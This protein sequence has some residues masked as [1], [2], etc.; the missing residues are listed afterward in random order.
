M[1]VE[2]YVDAKLANFEIVL[3]KTL[4]AVERGR[5]KLS[6]RHELERL[7][8]GGPAEGEPATFLDEP[9]GD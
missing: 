6:G 1:E 3:S 8:T 2:D 5:E 9:L 4:S 7:G